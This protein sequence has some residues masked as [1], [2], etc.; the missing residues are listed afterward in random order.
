[1]RLARTTMTRIRRTR[2]RAARDQRAHTLVE[3]M[4]TA[5]LI[6]ALV[7]TVGTVLA[8]IQHTQPQ[9]SDRAAQIQRGQVLM[10]RLTR[11]LRQARGVI[12]VPSASQITFETYARR[13][14]CGGA[15]LA[16][17]DTSP[18]IACQ[19]TYGCSSGACSR[20]EVAPGGS[21]GTPVELVRGLDSSL[22]FS[23]SPSA[24]DAAYV[25]IRL[26]FPGPQ[27][28]DAVTLDD[29]VNLRNVSRLQ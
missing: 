8:V 10:E 6:I 26:V 1:M 3:L 28:D 22:P 19:V 12:G 2:E 21:G 25:G 18:A 11:E 14:A 5:G 24:S 13:T 20:T 9:V 15:A 16:Q 7:A 29:G 27:D 4:V 23:Y 17:A